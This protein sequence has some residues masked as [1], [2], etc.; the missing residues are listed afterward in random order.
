[1]RAQLNVLERRAPGGVT[2]AVGETLAGMGRTNEWPPHLDTESERARAFTH[3]PIRRSPKRDEQPLVLLIQR[4]GNDASGIC[5]HLE[6]D[7]FRVRRASRDPGAVVLASRCRP[8]VVLLQTD[9]IDNGLE[10]MR[11]ILREV[12]APVIIVAAGDNSDS[13]AALECGADDYM[14]EPAALPEIAARARAAVR[15]TTRRPEGR[16]RQLGALE[17][18]RPARRACAGNRRLS[19]TPSEY[20]IL[21]VLS[22]TPGQVVTHDDLVR[23]I[24]ECKANSVAALGQRV[25]RLRSKLSAAGVNTPF[26]TAVRGVGYRLDD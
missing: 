16:V 25:R 9:A 15:R 23:A 14:V 12:A 26:I 18:D 1:M 24:G 17:L 22:R 7:A 5:D 10:L 20:T 19:L 4:S 6:G 8:D 13:V 2:G 11:Q 21:E 3:N